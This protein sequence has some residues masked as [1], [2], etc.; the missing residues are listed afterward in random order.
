MKG[1]NNMALNI[2]TEAGSFLPF[3]KYNAKADKWFKREDKQDVEISRPT[4]VADFKNIKTGWF[5]YEEGQ[6]PSIVLDPSLEVKAAKPSDKH[7]RGFEMELF[8]KNSFGGVVKFGSASM[9]VCNAI[10]E[11]YNEYE[12]SAEAKAGQLPVVEVAGSTPQKDK[13]G[14]NYKPTFKIVKYVDRPAEFDEAQET[15]SPAAA[16]PQQAAPVRK[17]VN[18]F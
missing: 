10:A 17:V 14:T 7:K 9:H 8:S 16:T 15:V 11:L 6:A 4:F 13:F 5:H 1:L 3:I 2:T 18:E 12:A